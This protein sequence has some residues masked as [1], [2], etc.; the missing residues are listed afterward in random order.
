MSPPRRS[1]TSVWCCARGQASC[2]EALGELRTPHSLNPRN[3]LHRVGIAEPFKASMATWEM[4]AGE[5]EK[6]KGL[7]RGSRGKKMKKGTNHGPRAIGFNRNEDWATIRI[8]PGLARSGLPPAEIA[9]AMRVSVKCT[10]CHC[11]SR[12]NSFGRLVRRVD[13]GASG[14]A[15]QLRLLLLFGAPEPVLAEAGRKQTVQRA[16]SHY[17]ELR[18]QGKESHVCHHENFGPGDGVGTDSS[19]HWVRV[20]LGRH[21]LQ[22][23]LTLSKRGCQH[24]SELW[25][26]G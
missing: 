7:E 21:G 18:A 11:A 15:R 24:I 14:R 6:R 20:Q 25:V 26:N 17:Q 2:S 9:V 22:G 10:Q 8:H 5:R 23:G 13:D 4:T 19:G 3:G 12:E 1:R 16:H